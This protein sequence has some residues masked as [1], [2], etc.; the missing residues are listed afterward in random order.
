MYTLLGLQ[1]GQTKND[2]N[3]FRS[4]YVWSMLRLV[5][6]SGNTQLHGLSSPFLLS[7]QL[8]GPGSISPRKLHSTPSDLR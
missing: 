1:F 3:T 6:L 2:D 8:N 4:K 7:V 5:F